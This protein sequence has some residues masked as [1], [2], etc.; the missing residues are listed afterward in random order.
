MKNWKQKWKSSRIVIVF[1]IC[2]ILFCFIQILRME[3]Q[4]HQARVEYSRARE[5]AS[6]LA[7]KDSGSKHSVSRSEKAGQ[8]VEKRSVVSSNTM[9]LNISSNETI[10]LDSLHRINSDAV[11]WIRF[12]EAGIDYPVVQGSDNDY[13]L[14]HTFEKRENSSGC[15]FL[16]SAQAPEMTDYNTFIYGHN[17]KDG[18]M[19]GNLRKTCREKGFGEDSHDLS[20]YIDQGVIRYRIFSSYEDTPNSK[21]FWK[22]RNEE[23]YRQYLKSITDKSEIDYHIKPD[24]HMPSITLVTCMGSGSEK[25]RYF[26][27]L[28]H[29]K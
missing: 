23:E 28:I 20:L 29:V 13:Y 15:I 9:Y 27:H 26:V 4:K 8:D 21:S 19:F 18:T 17:R 22:C 16:D 14:N 11:A 6:I 7:D 12:E 2:L 1:S 3:G 10:D 5:K 24:V 25:K